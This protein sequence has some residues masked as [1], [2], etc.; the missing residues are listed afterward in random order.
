MWA[1]NI[2][3][4]RLEPCLHV[5]MESLGVSRSIGVPINVD[6]GLLSHVEPNYLGLLLIA[7]F[8]YLIKNFLETS[9]GRLSRTKHR[10]ISDLPK[11]WGS[12]NFSLL[13]QAVNVLKM[14]NFGLVVSQ[15]HAWFN[16]LNEIQFYDERNLF[17]MLAPTEAPGA[18]DPACPVPQEPRLLY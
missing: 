17:Y 2:G 18:V 5:V 10:K 6:D 13:G 14:I 3:I 7:T 11:V 9:F 4:I 16:C 8:R 12:F 15:V 1:V